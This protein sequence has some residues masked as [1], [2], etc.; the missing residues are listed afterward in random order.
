MTD[1]LPCRFCG[2]TNIEEFDRSERN[3]YAAIRCGDCPAAILSLDKT[4]DELWA[5][6]DAPIVLTNGMVID[7]MR[8]PKRNLCT[9]P[10]RAP[11][12]QFSGRYPQEHQA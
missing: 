5:I 4:P 6:W 8:K 10:E 2:G 7:F 1:H 9:V 3:G 12:E 11:N